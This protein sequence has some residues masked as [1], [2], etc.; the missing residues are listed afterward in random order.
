MS[1]GIIV[2]IVIGIVLLWGVILGARGQKKWK[3]I[4][5]DQFTKAGLVK[6]PDARDYVENTITT[7]FHSEAKIFNEINDIKKF[8]LRVKRSISAM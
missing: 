6:A 2:I 8:R 1:I 4:I 3:K 5:V 7:L